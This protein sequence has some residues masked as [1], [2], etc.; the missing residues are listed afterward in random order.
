MQA[1]VESGRITAL[2][3]VLHQDD[4]AVVP[5][6]GS[7]TPARLDCRFRRVAPAAGRKFLQGFAA[8]WYVISLRFRSFRQDVSA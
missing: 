8:T 1:V 4:A 6:I 5:C 3:W 2:P 7:G